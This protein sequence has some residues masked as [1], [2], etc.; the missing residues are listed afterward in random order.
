LFNPD[1]AQRCDCGYDFETKTV[2]QAYFKQKLPRQF[3]T[4]LIFLAVWGFAQ[5]AS[6][7]FVSVGSDDPTQLVAV[8]PLGCWFMLIW[9]L[10]SKMIAKKNWARLWLAAL[11]FPAGLL[12]G[13]S[14]EA[15][16][17]CLQK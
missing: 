4:Y 1:T 8:V 9:W 15:R 5:I 6:V 12:V 11:T 7:V 17:Y 3:R 2:Q 10:Y 14:T 16:L 13:L